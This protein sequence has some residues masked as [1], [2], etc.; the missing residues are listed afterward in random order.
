V[1]IGEKVSAHSTALAFWPDDAG[2]R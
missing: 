1:A 2:G